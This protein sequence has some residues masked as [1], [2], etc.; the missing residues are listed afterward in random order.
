MNTPSVKT[1]LKAFP[2]IDRKTAQA[3]KLAMVE[4]QPAPRDWHSNGRRIDRQMHRINELLE[5]HGVEYVPRDN[6]TYFEAFG[7][8]YCNAG[9][10]YNATVIYD[11]KKGRF[12]VA[13]VGDIIERNPRRFAD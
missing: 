5:M 2:H 10:L 11:R 12:I 4:D 3:V 13:S 8:D 9:D 7:L 6:D 1:L